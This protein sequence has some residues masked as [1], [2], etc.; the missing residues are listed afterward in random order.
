MSTEQVCLRQTPFQHLDAEALAWAAEHGTR[1]PGCGG[2]MVRVKSRDGSRL[3]WGCV[4]CDLRQGEEPKRVRVEAE[5]HSAMARPE[6]AASE[7][8]DG[9]DAD[10][11]IGVPE[12]VKV[13]GIGKSTLRRAIKDGTLT[14]P[15]VER[16]KGHPGPPVRMLRRSEV[17]ALR[18]EVRP[19]KRRAPAAELAPAPEPERP[20]E[21]PEP[22]QPAADRLL[23]EYRAV[24]SRCTELAAALAEARARLAELESQ[25]EEAMHDKADARERLNRALDELGR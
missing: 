6:A 8:S 4:P 23:A 7:A 15:L 17:E 11:L 22:S 24:A 16:V 2:L 10:G 3:V 19:R 13:Y 5:A 14:A 1:C 9:G 18:G 25:A 21:P 20:P 12:A